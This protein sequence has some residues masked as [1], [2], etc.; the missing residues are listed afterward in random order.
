MP[1][2]DRPKGTVEGLLTKLVREPDGCWLWPGKRRPDGYGVANVQG[3]GVRVHRAV[4]EHLRGPIEPKLVLHH[5]CRQRHCANPDHLEPCGIHENVLKDCPDFYGRSERMKTHCDHGHP[6]SGENLALVSGT[7]ICRTCRKQ[8]KAEYRA[9]MKN[10][11]S[12]G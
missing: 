5:T 10:G 6:L 11:T 12:A 3:R 2:Y 4:Y 7:R 9:R 8:R 1:G